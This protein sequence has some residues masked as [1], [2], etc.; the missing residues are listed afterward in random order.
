MTV[1]FQAMSLSP[2]A[3]TS[4]DGSTARIAATYLPRFR[5]YVLA[6][7][8]P[9]TQSPQISLPIS[10]YFTRYGSGWPS[11]ARNDPYLELGGPL[12]YSTHAAAS[13]TVAPPPSTFTVIDGSAPAA[14]AN[15]TNSSVP[16][17]L[18]SGSF[19]HDRLV[20]VTRSSRGPTPHHQR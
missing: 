9:R 7:E 15:A 13:S 12:Q 5:A 2:T 4:I 11:R 18:G 19:F 8:C 10:Q 1:R 3:I 20:Q 6:S 17:S 16:K 14:R